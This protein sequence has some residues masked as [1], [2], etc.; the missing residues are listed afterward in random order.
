MYEKA[1]NPANF[2]KEGDEESKQ[3]ATSVKVVNGTASKKHFNKVL[4]SIEAALSDGSQ[5]VN[6]GNK[7]S[8]ADADF[9]NQVGEGKPSPLVYPHT[10]GW[11]AQ[12]SKFSEEERKLWK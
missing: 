1:W 11:W 6:G 8:A 7:P 4:E 10:F 9:F 12:I 5:F 3:A 2:P